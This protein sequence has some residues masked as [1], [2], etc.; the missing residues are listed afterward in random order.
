MLTP[1]EDR[2]AGACIRTLDLAAEMSPWMDQCTNRDEFEIH[3]IHA[4]Q[5]IKLLFK[6]YQS[7]D[8]VRKL[9]D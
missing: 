8:Q 3:I 9:M 2:L 4:L 1:S 6:I 7:T 5:V